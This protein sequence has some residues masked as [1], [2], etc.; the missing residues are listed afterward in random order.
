MEF[1]KTNKIN[2]SYIPAETIDSILSNIL[3]REFKSLTRSEAKVVLYRFESNKII[4][5]Y[6]RMNICRFC[7]VVG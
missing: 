3:L 7:R 2:N 4:L 1:K 6:E 5:T